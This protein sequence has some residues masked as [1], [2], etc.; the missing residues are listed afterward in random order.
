MQDLIRQAVELCVISAVRQIWGSPS[1]EGE[2]VGP[3]FQKVKK[4]DRGNNRPVSLTSVPGKT[5]REYYSG[6]Y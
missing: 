5:A 4:K 3:V 1:L 2:N 6:C